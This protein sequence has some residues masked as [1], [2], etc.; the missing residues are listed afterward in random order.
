[1]AETFTV[2]DEGLRAVKGPGKFGGELLLTRLFWGTG[3]DGF[4]DAD[5]EEAGEGNG[6][7]SL[8]LFDPKDAAEVIANLNSMAREQK[9][10]P[11]T[12]GEERLIRD[13]GG[14]VVFESSD[15]MIES[16]YFETA[17]AAQKKWD[18]IEAEIAE[19]EAGFD[20]T[21][22]DY[23]RERASEASKEGTRFMS[24]EGAPE[25]DAAEGATPASDDYRDLLNE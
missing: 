16:T 5:M 17:A 24:G 10:A 20:E 1:M 2:D 19:E 9:I 21:D 4:S 18:D 11:L 7:Y 25:V 13:G 3:L 22:P 23:E 15:G 14:L 8:F 6:A 12:D